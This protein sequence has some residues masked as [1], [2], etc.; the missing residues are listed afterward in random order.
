MTIEIINEH[1]N[2][3]M[4]S[5]MVNE[6]PTMNLEIRNQKDFLMNELKNDYGLYIMITEI[7]KK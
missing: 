6:R 2:S 1:E 3:W 4:E 7:R 5:K